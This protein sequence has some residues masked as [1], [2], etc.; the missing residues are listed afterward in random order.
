[1]FEE[2]RIIWGLLNG[3]KVLEISF[4]SC[5]T[6]SPFSVYSWNRIAA[7]PFGERG[8]R[9][10]K[11]VLK[12]EKCGIFIAA[13]AVIRYIRL[14]RAARTP[15][16]CTS[17]AKLCA[18][19]PLQTLATGMSSSTYWDAHARV[20]SHLYIRPDVIFTSRSKIALRLPVPSF[21]L[22]QSE[23][24]KKNRSKIVDKCEKNREWLAE[25]TCGGSYASIPDERTQY[26]YTIMCIMTPTCRWGV[27]RDYGAFG[28]TQASCVIQS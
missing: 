11:R 8:A 22:D 19:P 1:M 23:K 25:L 10:I 9:W 20:V 17:L 27:T 24:W 26:A 2:S 4:T 13:A 16:L 14:W 15:A 6:I 18:S 12:T 21:L 7:V 3:L 28:T 5:E